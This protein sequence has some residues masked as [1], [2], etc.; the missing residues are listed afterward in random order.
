MTC[1]RF[2]TLSLLSIFISLSLLLSLPIRAKNSM[3]AL[4]GKSTNADSSMPMKVNQDS[5]IYAVVGGKIQKAGWLLKHSVLL[6]QP[7]KDNFYRFH[8][9]NS[10]GY[11][12]QQHAIEEK[13]QFPV[14]TLK[15]LNQHVY[16][17]LITTEKP[18]II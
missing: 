16:N 4:F 18:P 8:F 7:A 15:L 5:V 13:N 6:I 2:I 1:C 10:Y 9:G 11:I 12:V 14:Y 17:Y 3:V